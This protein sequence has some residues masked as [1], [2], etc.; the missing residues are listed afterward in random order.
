MTT[1][2]IINLLNNLTDEEFNLLISN[3]EK[4]I[5]SKKKNRKKPLKMQYQG[6]E[7]AKR[8]FNSSKKKK[9]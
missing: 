9:K 4:D 8:I 1:K 7:N 6:E 5:L 3:A 2:E